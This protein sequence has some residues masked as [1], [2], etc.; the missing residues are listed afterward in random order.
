MYLR[1]FK[2]KK[3]LNNAFK[4]N[5][6]PFCMYMYIPGFIWPLHYK[7]ESTAVAPSI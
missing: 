7:N 3:L 5:L 2:V 1:F 6:K 4:F